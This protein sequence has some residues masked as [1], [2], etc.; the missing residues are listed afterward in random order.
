MK[1]IYYTKK[2]AMKAIDEIIAENPDYSA[3]KSITDFGC[4]FEESDSFAQNVKGS[5]AGECNAYII[6]NEN[7]DTEAII[8]WW[9]DED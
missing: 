3:R 5:C 1:K 6:E 8:A 7:L 9:T 2:E 4:D